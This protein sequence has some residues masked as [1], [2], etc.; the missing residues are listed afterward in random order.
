M[1]LARKSS[2]IDS[3]QQNFAFVTDV[4]RKDLVPFLNVFVSGGYYFRDTLTIEAPMVR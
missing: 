4:S 1:N 3:N 2:L